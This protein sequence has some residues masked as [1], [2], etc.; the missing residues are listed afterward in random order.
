MAI[1]IPIRTTAYARDGFQ[2]AAIIWKAG[3][4]PIPAPG[5]KSRCQMD[6]GK[7]SPAINSFN[8]LIQTH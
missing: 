1:T 7:M 3:K 6:I 5:K 8:K 2:P 4:T